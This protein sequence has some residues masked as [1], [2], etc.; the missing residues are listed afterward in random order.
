MALTEFVTPFCDAFKEDFDRL[1]ADRDPKKFRDDL[2]EAL[3]M[4]TE[5]P[6]SRG[7]MVSILQYSQR[8]KGYLEYAKLIEYE[9]LTVFKIRCKDSSNKRAAQG[10]FRIIALHA[11][12]QRRSFLLRMY[13][14][15]N[16]SDIEPDELLEGLKHALSWL[17]EHFGDQKKKKK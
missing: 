16:Q 17:Q 10:A 9:G 12:N 11:P 15:T 5:H 8:T 3:N 2:L 1:K 6:A 14:K 4:F 13:A 7:D